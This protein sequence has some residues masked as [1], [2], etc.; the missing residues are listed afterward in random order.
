MKAI[1]IVE[2]NLKSPSPRLKREIGIL[3]FR[4]YREPAEEHAIYDRS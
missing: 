4:Q 1:F 2:S 3:T